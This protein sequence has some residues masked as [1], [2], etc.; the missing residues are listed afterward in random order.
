MNDL[1]PCSVHVLTKNSEATIARCLE[2]LQSFAEVV[3]VDG[4]S[5]DRTREIAQSVPH[6]TG[7]DQNRAF[8]DSE[9]RVRD[10][11]AVRNDALARVLLPWFLYVDS[12]EVLTPEFLSSVRTA[13]LSGSFDAYTAFRRFVVRDEPVMRSAAYPALHLRLARRSAIAGGF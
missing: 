8:L 10:F 3:V 6:V 2:S 1:I 13:V 11:A 9:E 5:T 7:V 4:Y 12:D